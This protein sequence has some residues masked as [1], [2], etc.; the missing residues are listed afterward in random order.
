[1]ADRTVTTRWDGGMRA[2]SR[3]GRFEVVVDEPGSAGGTDT[4]PQPTDLFLVSVSSCF[5]LALAYVAR[6]QGVDLVDLEVTAVGRYAG[7]KFDRI[8]L[9]VSAEP[10]DE[11]AGLLEEAERLCYVSNTL[12]HQPALS[13]EVGP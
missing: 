13:V 12:R 11:V 8:V 7:L 2:V 4:G 6:K 10:R 3:A 1:M 5:A 9:T